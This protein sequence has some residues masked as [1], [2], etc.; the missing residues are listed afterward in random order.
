MLNFF[1]LPLNFFSFAKIYSEE[2]I[3]CALDYP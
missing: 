2:I 3:W 1:V